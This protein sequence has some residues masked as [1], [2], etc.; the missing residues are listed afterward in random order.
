MVKPRPR[1]D[2]LKERTTK[3]VLSVVIPAYN[4]AQRIEPSLERIRVYLASR[5]EPIEIVVVDDGSNDG[6]SAVV[7]R[8]IPKFAES[9]LELRLLGDGKNHG[10]GSAVRVGMLA[11]KGDIV[12]FSDADLSAPIDELPKL[13]DP[14]RAG[15][16][17]IAIGSRALDRSLV[18]VHQSVAREVAGRVFNLLMRALTGM[19]FHDTQ[20]GFKA[21]RAEAAREVFGRVLIERFGFDVE[22]LYVARKFGYSIR[23]VPVIWNN[24]EGSTV[25]LLSGING[26]AD[27]LR[28]RFNDIRGR[29]GR[30]NASK[31]KTADRR[32]S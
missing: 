12:L 5:D 29:Y 20:C 21:F 8:E 28:V 23:E 32:P 10:K 2:P 30:R 24:V 11:A 19:P 9:G 16:V 7:E 6:T 17:D 27:V 26:Y 3:P 4:E 22:A 14:I 18:G 13:V 31:T 1:G 25:G 15:E